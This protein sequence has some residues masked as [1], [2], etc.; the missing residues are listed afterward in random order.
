MALADFF[1]SLLTFVAIYSLFGI[2]LNVKYGFTGLIDF[3]HVAYFMIGAY[4]T[5]VLTMP[6]G[7]GTTYEGSGR[8]RPPSPS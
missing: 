3:G 6:A 4:V 8:P 1:V 2:G 5:V 7:G